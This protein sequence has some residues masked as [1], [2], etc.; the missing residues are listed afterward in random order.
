M[1]LSNQQSQF[2]YSFSII[3]I[4]KQF[5]TIKLLIDD[6]VVFELKKVFQS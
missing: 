3:H 1:K 5:K 6:A 2:N 4:Y